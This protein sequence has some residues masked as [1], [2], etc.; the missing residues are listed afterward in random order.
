MRRSSPSSPKSW[1][2]RGGPRRG[3]F[4]VV[5][6]NE[7]ASAVPLV[8]PAATATPTAN[9]ANRLTLGLTRRRGAGCG[10]RTGCVVAATERRRRERRRTDH[11]SEREQAK[12]ELELVARQRLAEDDRTR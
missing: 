9:V 6:T 1:S 11:Q 2:G 4:P 3:S 12:R 7:S 5:P 10:G 8:A